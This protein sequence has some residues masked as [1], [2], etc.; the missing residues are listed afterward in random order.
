MICQLLA[1]NGIRF[2]EK[3]DTL[4][5]CQFLPANATMDARKSICIILNRIYKQKYASSP[6]QLLQPG[7]GPASAELL[8]AFFWFFLIGLTDIWNAKIFKH[9]QRSINA[10]LLLG[11]F[12][13][14]LI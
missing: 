2:P 5:K 14:L 11:V 10:F 6:P 13:R 8:D 7:L 1:V 4:E 12:K 9:H 3:V